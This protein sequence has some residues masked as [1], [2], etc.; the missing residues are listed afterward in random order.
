MPQVT[1][2][3]LV[4]LE[5]AAAAVLGGFALDGVWRIVGSAVAGVVLLLAVVPVRRRWLYQLV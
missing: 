3:Q 1:R 4:L 5:L 2:A